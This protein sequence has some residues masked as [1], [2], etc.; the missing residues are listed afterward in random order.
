MLHLSFHVSS[1]MQAMLA[2]TYALM[3]ISL[4]YTIFVVISGTGGLV[5]ILRQAA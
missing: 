3:L 5:E 1:A 4:V 2:L